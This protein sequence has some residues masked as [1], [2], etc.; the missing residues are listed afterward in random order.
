MAEKN[1]KI[2]SPGGER[3]EGHTW[4]IRIT[5]KDRKKRKKQIR[6]DDEIRNEE[7]RKKIRHKRER[8][9]K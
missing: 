8:K 1:K 3:G 6:D 5:E 2:R 9:S 7:K 4:E